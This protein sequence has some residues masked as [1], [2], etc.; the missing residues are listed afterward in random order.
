[1]KAFAKLDRDKDGVVTLDDIKGVYSGAKHPDVLSGRRSE[2][3]VLTEFL[4]T[5]EQH[6]AYIVCG[7]A[8]NAPRRSRARETAR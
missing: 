7:R 6:Y 4:D 2:E 1:M 5:F 8:D 3:D